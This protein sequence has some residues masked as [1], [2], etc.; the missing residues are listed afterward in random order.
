MTSILNG[1]RKE[2]GINPSKFNFVQSYAKTKDKLWISWNI[3]P[4]YDETD[5]LVGLIAIGYDIT[6]IKKMEDKFKRAKEEAEAANIAKSEFLANMSHEIRTPLNGVIGF[7]D[8]LLKRETNTEKLEMLQMI[9]NSGET[10]LEMIN[11]ILDLSKI[12]AGKIELENKPFNLNKAFMQCI[13]MFEASAYTKGLRLDYQIDNSLLVDVIGDEVRFKQILMNLINNAIK[14]TGKG[15]VGVYARKVTEESHYITASFSVSDTGIGIP[16]NKVDRVFERF[17]QG[18]LTITKKYGG[19]GLGLSIVKEIL[20]LMDG[21]IEVISKE[22]AGSK[23]VFEISFKKI[24]DSVTIG[25]IILL[26]DKNH[27]MVLD[28][29]V[30][31]DNETSQKLIKRL[32]E[33]KGYSVDIAENGM[34]VLNKIEER[35]YDLILMDI[36]MPIMDGLETTRQIR[37]KGNKIK[38][39]ALTAFAM[40]GDHEKCFS[41]GMD[42]Y[43]AKPINRDELFEKLEKVFN[44]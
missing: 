32:I 23:F 26:K 20:D 39:I 38:I 44:G 6:D 8:I 13:K 34:E 31:E 28:I 36:Q 7:T 2:G 21:H 12:E 19:T 11:Q 42:D 15:S 22:G 30:A 16:E 24:E 40:D 41:A 29:L 5:K 33:G 35:K 10:L 37:K 25:D 4:I 43:I 1:Y 27:P 14:F 3:K 17:Y 9:Y 18:D